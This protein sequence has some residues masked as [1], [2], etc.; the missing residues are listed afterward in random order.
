MFVLN[1]ILKCY[2]GTEAPSWSSVAFWPKVTKRPFTAQL[3]KLYLAHHQTKLKRN[4]LQCKPLS[5]LDPVRRF[6]TFNV[7]DV[8]I[9]DFEKDF[10]K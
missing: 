7:A 1:F 3:T 10:Q 6:R 2:R 9:F 5:S 8:I 4:F